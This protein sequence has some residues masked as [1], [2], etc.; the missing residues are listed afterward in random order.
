MPISVFEFI[1][2]LQDSTT[3]DMPWK[4]GQ[5]FAAQ[6]GMHRVACCYGAL[7][8]GGPKD[9]PVLAKQPLVRGTFSKRIGNPWS[10]QELFR[11]DPLVERVLAS[12]VPF[13]WGTEFFGAQKMD[14]DVRA[15]YEDLRDDGAR[16]MFVVPLRNK[17]RLGFGFDL[18]GA[19]LPRAEFEAL[20]ARDGAALA[21]FAFYCDFRL[22]EL[23]HNQR[24]ATHQLATRETECLQL[25]TTGLKNEVIAARMGIT[26]HTVQLHLSS[27]KKKLGAAT[28]EQALAKALMFGI[29]TA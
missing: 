28:R 3:M 18:F 26:I 29:I 16:S 21:L 5:E 4:Q 27:A 6:H 2:R 1:D 8:P 14:T 23:W 7:R 25:L 11:R 10:R 15:F 17:R 12:P 13:F 24:N 9:K 19:D 22:I 20:I